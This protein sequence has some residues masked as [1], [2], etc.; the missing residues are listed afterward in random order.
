MNRDTILVIKTAIFGKNAAAIPL[1]FP[2]CGLHSAAVDGD[3]AIVGVNAETT[4]A[5]GFARGIHGT[6][7]N[8]NRAAS[9]NAAAVAMLSWSTINR[10]RGVV[11]AA[12]GETAFTQIYSAAGS[13]PATQRV[14]GVLAHQLNGQIARRAVNGHALTTIAIFLCFF[15]RCVFKS[16]GAAVPHDV[17]VFSIRTLYCYHA[18][19]CVCDGVNSGGT[20]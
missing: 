5:S 12:Y 4:P 13:V 17:V 14:H 16:Q 7:V 10:Q 20:F 11:L 18:G 19:V 9:V 1:R 3:C 6:A 8:R 2:A 15:D